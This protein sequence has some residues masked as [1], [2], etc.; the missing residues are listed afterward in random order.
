MKFAQLFLTLSENRIFLKEKK[1]KKFNE[2]FLF[3]ILD[4]SLFFNLLKVNNLL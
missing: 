1:I 3:K 2:I 4:I